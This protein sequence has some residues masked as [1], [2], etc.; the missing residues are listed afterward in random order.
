MCTPACSAPGA[1]PFVGRSRYYIGKGSG[2]G[3][4]SDQE[5]AVFEPEV[6]FQITFIFVGTQSQIGRG[7]VGFPNTPEDMTAIGSLAKRTGKHGRQQN[8]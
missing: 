1:T 6:G 5:I 7:M 4:F 2:G 8:G 3:I